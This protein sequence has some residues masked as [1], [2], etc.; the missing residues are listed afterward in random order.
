[1]NDQERA[2]GRIRAWA[3][4]YKDESRSGIRETMKLVYEEAEAALAAREEPQHAKTHEYEMPERV[5]RVLDLIMSS[6]DV[7]PIARAFHEAYEKLAPEWGYKTRP[8]SAV[9]WE[10]VPAAN[11]GL[12][13]SVIHQLIEDGVLAAREDTERPEEV[14]RL[15]EGLE[16]ALAERAARGDPRGLESWHCGGHGRAAGHRATGRP[17][18]AREV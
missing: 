14:T 2:L 17:P 1:M 5:V 15:R 13:C 12:M 7:D 9:P 10:Q 4:H 16:R 6:K 18:S 8:E 11:K 3:S